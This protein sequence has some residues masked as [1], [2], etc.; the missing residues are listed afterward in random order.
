MK[1]SILTGILFF[2]PSCVTPV[3]LQ[4]QKQK[5]LT[6]TYDSLSP[7][8]QKNI[9]VS[10]FFWGMFTP[11]SQNNDIS[12]VCSHKYS[13]KITRSFSQV[14]ASLFTLGFYTPATLRITCDSG[15]LDKEE[16]NFHDFEEEEDSDFD[17]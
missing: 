17:Y 4:Y 8:E 10:S 2:L 13:A 9:K 11:H 5:N 3:T 16:T 12:E 14:L 6:N 7:L 1:Y 15:T